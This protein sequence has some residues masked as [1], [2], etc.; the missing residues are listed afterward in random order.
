[1]SRPWEDKAV[2]KATKQKYG[3][4]VDIAKYFTGRGFPVSETT[5]RRWADTHGIRNSTIE[6]KLQRA[7][8]ELRAAKEDAKEALSETKRVIRESEKEI[9]DIEARPRQATPNELVAAERELEKARVNAS[10]YRTIARSLAR[11]TNIIEEVRDIL[12]PVYEDWVLPQLDLPESLGS[13]NDEPYTL[14]LSLNDMHFGEIIESR[15][16][17][18]L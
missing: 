3:T 9:R 13:D 12:A 1:M 11:E 18:H 6:A 16:V 5:I 7:Q 17:N 15:T 4:W 8:E 14:L 2:F 10:K